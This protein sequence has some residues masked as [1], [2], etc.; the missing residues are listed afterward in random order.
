MPRTIAH[1]PR[2]DN[3]HIRALHVY[4]G[5]LYGGV[6]RMLATFA[7]TGA[8]GL[9]QRFALCFEGRLAE[10]IR[11]A[12]APLEMLGEV[13]VSRPWTAVRA[14]RRLGAVL[15]GARP[16]AVICHSSWT[17][18]LFADVARRRGIPLVFWLHDAVTGATWADRLAKRTRPDLAVCTSRF[19]GETLDRLWAHLP[20]EVVYPPA[21]RPRAE[22]VDRRA[23]RERL[24]TP[25]ADVVILQASRM[26]PWKGHRL[27]VEG[28]A[29]IREVAGWTCWVAG[30]AQRPH[31][32]AHLAEVYALA[33]QLGV[34]GRIRF[35]GQRNDVPALMASADVLCQPNLGPEPFGIAFVEAMHAGLPIVA[36][37]L[38]GAR[39]I[40]DPACGILVPPRD[41]D[42]LAQ[43][44]HR[45]IGDAELR[46]RLGAAG[47]AHARALCD[48]HQQT[49]RLGDV[50]QNLIHPT[51]G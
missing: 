29:G 1:H 44:L 37:A 13:R 36:T 46:A 7:A 2:P 35:L 8:E 28:L 20:A 45:L 38:G 15:D 41:H 25:A 23:V 18:G 32:E 17:H 11:A 47:P 12:G 4:S 27:L 10:E 43:A 31:E 14:R 19:A 48:P 9:E 21:P 26:E 16:D 30:G 34:A 40:V 24:R 49:T 5:N 3:P 6:E 51:A 50:L 22:A 42:A 33:Q 39:E